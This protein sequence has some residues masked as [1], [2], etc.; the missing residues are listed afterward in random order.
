MS[1]VSPQIQFSDGQWPDC[2]VT[3]DL[4]IEN[5]ILWCE[6]QS[7]VQSAEVM[8]W[9][10]WEHQLTP[11]L[12]QATFLFR[13]VGNKQCNILEPTPNYNMNIIN[14]CQTFTQNT[15]TRVT[16]LLF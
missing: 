3:F 1:A 10:K 16:E 15:E 2:P 6:L 14:L 12:V 5:L 7:G 4:N 13:L 9:T 11:T 8:Y